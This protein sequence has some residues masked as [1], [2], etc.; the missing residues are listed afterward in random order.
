[1][2]PAVT[3]ADRRGAGEPPV[4]TDD[5]RAIVRVGVAVMVLFFGGLGGWAA[6]APL[7]S[8]ALAPGIVKVEANRQAVQHP[9]GGVI[10]AIL[11]R[12]GD[13][14]TEGQVLVRLDDTAARAQVDQ[15]QAQWDAYKALEARL[16]AERD[17]R[18]AIAFDPALAARRADPRINELMTGQENLFE[19][20][21]RA[22]SGQTAVLRQRIAQIED[23]ITGLQGQAASQSQQLALIQDE[24]GG[25][26][27]LYARGY[28][29]R[30]KLL[31]LERTAAALTGQQGEYVANIGRSRQQIG[32]AQMQIMQLGRDRLA[33]VSDQL[34][35]AQTHL[36]DIEPRLRAARDTLARTELR[37]PQ[38]GT[39]VGLS[40]FTVGGVIGRGDRVLDIV[41][42]DSPLI[43]EAQLAPQDIDEVTEGL[44]AEVHLTA[45]KQR[46]VPIVHGA[47]RHVSADRL[48]DQ[49]T[50]TGYYQVEVEIDRRE[51][52]PARGLYLV[53]GM[54]ADVMIPLKARTALDYL[55]APLTAG[56]NKAFREK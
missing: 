30:T 40:V 18:E 5:A 32:E 50:G 22:L 29:P 34:R 53:P 36:N 7:A 20:R 19:A 2:T 15:I 27:T 55:A 35:D 47:V 14:V 38:A 10:K 8:A 42:S 46:A 41:P 9:D 21:R 3:R 26:R 37:A 12:D 24:L 39:V 44:T 13:R 23:T 43:V 17:D 25:T 33:E 4:V 56:F 48:T 45:F 1:M 52:D 11:V 28:A 31:E 6:T 51:L 49:R 16:I 54:P